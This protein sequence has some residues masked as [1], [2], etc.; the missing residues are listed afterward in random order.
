MSPE[1]VKTVA[2]FAVAGAA[3]AGGKIAEVAVRLLCNKCK[4]DVSKTEKIVRQQIVK[5]AAQSICRQAVSSSIR[6]MV[7][8]GLYK[9]TEQAIFTLMAHD[10]ERSQELCRTVA[11]TTSL[12]MTV[13]GTVLWIRCL[14]PTA[15]RLYHSYTPNHNPNAS[16]FSDMAALM[17]Q[18][19]VSTLI[20]HISKKLE[21]KGCE[22]TRLENFA[23]R[24]VEITIK[25]PFEDDETKTN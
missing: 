20:S 25:N 15:E 10:G 23:K 14:A 7:V 21:E 5:I 4:N 16:L 3:W 1:K 18:S 19:Y 6:G 17:D 9:A 8:Y 22:S 12:C 13:A 11:Q 24:V 2:G